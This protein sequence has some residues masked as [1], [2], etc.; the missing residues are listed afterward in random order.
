MKQGCLSIPLQQLKSSFLREGYGVI[1]LC[2]LIQTKENWIEELTPRSF[3]GFITK[4]SSHA[5]NNK[6]AK[7]AFLKSDA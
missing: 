6:H 2:K 4:L 1:Q 5:S 3:N 7:L